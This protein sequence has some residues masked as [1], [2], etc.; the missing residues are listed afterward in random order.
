[1]GIFWTQK[2]SRRAARAVD[3]ES[4]EDPPDGLGRRHKV[5]AGGHD[6]DR[7]HGLG[8][9]KRPN[10]KLCIAQQGRQKQCTGKAA[11]Y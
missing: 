8:L 7:A 1:M 4:V 3:A 10:V 2:K 6:M 9:R 11:Q 5:V